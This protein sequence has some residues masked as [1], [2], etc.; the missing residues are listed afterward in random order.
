LPARDLVSKHAEDRRGQLGV[1][2][3]HTRKGHRAA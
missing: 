3:D 2:S 1:K